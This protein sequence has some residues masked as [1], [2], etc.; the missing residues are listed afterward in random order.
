[1]EIIRAFEEEINKDIPF[2]FVS[3]RQGDLPEFWAEVTKAK[4]IL[5]WEAKLN[6]SDMLRDIWNW[7]L[8]NPTGFD[9][10]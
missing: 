5:G 7:Q 8:K 1:M 3:R 2:E 4:N 6:L 9:S 10:T